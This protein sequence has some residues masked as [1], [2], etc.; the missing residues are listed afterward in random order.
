LFCHKFPF[1]GEDTDAKGDMGG[2]EAVGNDNDDEPR[3]NGLM[4]D[5]SAALLERDLGE[6]MPEPVDAY[7]GRNSSGL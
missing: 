1:L 7:T 2:V 5:I 6:G 3:A 4:V